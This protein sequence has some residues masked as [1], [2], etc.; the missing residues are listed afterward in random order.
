MR[1]KIASHPTEEFAMTFIKAF[2]GLHHPVINHVVNLISSFGISY[3]LLCSSICSASNE[4]K[5][6]G[7]GS[8]QLSGTVK[9]L[10]FPG[11]P[12]YTSIKEGDYPER[13]PYLYLDKKIDVEMKA[14]KDV[15]EN[16][17]DN[18]RDIRLVQ[19]VVM[20]MND[21][22]V[23]KENLRI[24]IKGELSGPMTGHHHAKVLMDV[25][26]YTLDKNQN[27]VPIKN[28]RRSIA[29]SL[30]VSKGDGVDYYYTSLPSMK[31]D[32]RK[33]NF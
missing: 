8:E 23:I 22:K 12:N 10:I 30:R 21:F 33:N 19:L 31:S 24:T 11:R 7:A 20:N 5:H 25:Q 4:I 14:V 26:Q 32:L 18:V 17:Y 2:D 9:F 6:Y 15:K 3:I 29:H 1:V 27:V 28:F 13:Q 16:S